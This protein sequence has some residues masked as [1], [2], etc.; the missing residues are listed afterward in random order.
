MGTNG[1]PDGGSVG[2]LIVS[3]DSGVG[4]IVVDNPPKRNAMTSA[5]FATMGEVCRSWSADPAVR[6]VVIRGYGDVAFI[7]GGDIGELRAERAVGQRPDGA[8]PGAGAALSALDKPVIAMINGYCLGG[9]IAVAVAADIRLCSDDAQFGVPAARLGVG[10]P[11]E[12][13]ARLVALVGPGHT[14]EILFGGQ[15]MDAARA[16]RIGLVNRVL[17]KAELEDAVRGLALTIAANAP[18]SHAAH[19][20]SIRAAVGARSL[21]DRVEIDEA[22]AAAWRSNDF[23]EGRQAF[24]DRREPV[25]DGR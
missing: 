5:M 4:W 18:L 11:Y 21:L 23:R 3:V 8:P 9:G 19:K 10:Y 12:D 1:R 7:S 25:F 16:E 20:R 2:R 14:S 15:R 22:I 13:T 17:P 6:A 24:L